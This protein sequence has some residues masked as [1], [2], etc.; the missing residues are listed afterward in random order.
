MF[1][2]TLSLS[3]VS[4]NANRLDAATIDFLDQVIE[5]FVQWIHTHRER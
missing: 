3:C 5:R 4:V 2:Y 1:E